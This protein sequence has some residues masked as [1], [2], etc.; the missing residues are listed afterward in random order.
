MVVM[1][2]TGGG[3]AAAGAAGTIARTDA[4]RATNADAASVRRGVLI[5]SPGSRLDHL[6]TRGFGEGRAELP[7][8]VRRDAFVDDFG[9]ACG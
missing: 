5:G 1:M 7:E 9:G 3:T 6:Y 8:S 4:N 2:P